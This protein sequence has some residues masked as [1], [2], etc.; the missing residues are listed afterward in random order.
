MQTWYRLSC[1]RGVAN[2]DSLIQLSPTTTTLRGC[3]PSRA[4]AP[5]FTGYARFNKSVRAVAIVNSRFL[6]KYFRKLPAEVLE[7]DVKEV[8]RST[9]RR[10]ASLPRS[11]PESS[12]R[13]N[14][15]ASRTQS[16][17]QLATPRF[18]AVHM[19]GDLRLR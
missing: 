17:M 11:G 8:G 18:T 7:T 19:M 10:I 15:M 3:V 13:L 6:R 14:D 1:P 5:F 16:A 12:G 9:R 2:P 4:G